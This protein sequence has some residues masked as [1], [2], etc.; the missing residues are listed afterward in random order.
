MDFQTIV[1][2]MSAMTCVVSVEKLPDGKYGTI[3]IVAGNKAYIDSIEHPASGV[4]MLRDRFVPNSEYTDYLTRDLNFEDF[5]YRAAVGK[6]CLHSYVHPERMPVWFNMMFI[7]LDGDEEDIGYCLYMMEIDQEADSN[8]KLIYPLRPYPL[9]LTP[10]S[11]SGAP[12][13]SKLL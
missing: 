9:S 4:V 6:K 8:K 2:G 11:D 12:V 5:C 10:V 7:P 1:D 13:I 3:R